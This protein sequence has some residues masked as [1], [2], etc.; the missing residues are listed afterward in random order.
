M[1][2]RPSI[3]FP[4]ASA[5]H[6]RLACMAS[7]CSQAPADPAVLGRSDRNYLP[8]ASLG[9]KSQPV[10]IPEHSVA[11]G[12]VEFGHHAGLFLVLPLDLAGEYLDF[13]APCPETYEVGQTARVLGSLELGRSPAPGDIKHRLAE[14][15]VVI[16]D[17]FGGVRGA[18]RGDLDLGLHEMFL[19]RN[20]L[21]GFGAFGLRGGLAHVVR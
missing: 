20:R 15:E 5:V 18:G 3:S 4:T 6:W 21:G 1:P 16:G 7:Q 2:A 11:R 9:V 10:L 17:R 13:R 12:V 19:G 8:Q 14:K